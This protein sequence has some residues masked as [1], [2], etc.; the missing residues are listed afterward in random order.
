M[1]LC[2]ARWTPECAELPPDP[3][4]CRQSLQLLP[5][6]GD[7]QASVFDAFR[8]DQHVGH[9][10]HHGALASHHQNFQAVIVIQVN[11]ER[12]EDGV[13]EIVLDAGEFL[14]Q[15]AHVVI[16]DQGDGAHHLRVR[17]FPRLFDQ[18]LADQVAKGFGAVRV[19]A[20][21]DQ[22]IELLQQS[23][24][25]GDANPAQGA[26]AYNIVTPANAPILGGAGYQSVRSS[27]ISSSAPSALSALPSW[28]S[29]RFPQRL[30]VSALKSTISQLPSPPLWHE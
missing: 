7:G 23:A 30:R 19:T 18:F 22:L 8:A 12:G 10:P 3:R 14:A 25:D 16:I 29:L 6:G 4:L 11:V 26:H 17:R 15:Q 20:P 28:S 24:I 13:M 1:S 27:D 5:R 9:L 21:P 2:N